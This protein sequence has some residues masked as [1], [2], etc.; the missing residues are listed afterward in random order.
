MIKGIGQGDAM[1][2][3]FVEKM[4]NEILGQWRD[5]L[6]VFLLKLELLR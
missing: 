2:F 4:T 6:P 3:V 5:V 1:V